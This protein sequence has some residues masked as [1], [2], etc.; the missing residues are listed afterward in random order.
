MKILKNKILSYFMNSK[1]LQS[2]ILLS[3]MK[4]RNTFLTSSIKWI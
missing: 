4:Y 2:K 1:R 3:G